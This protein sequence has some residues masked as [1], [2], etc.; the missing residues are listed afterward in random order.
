MTR[1][2]LTPVQAELLIGIV[3]F[4]R[5]HGFPPSYR[6]MSRILGLKPVAGQAIR[7]HLRGLVRKGW[8]NALSG[9]RVINLVCKTDYV[10]IAPPT[11]AQLASRQATK[12]REIAAWARRRS[13]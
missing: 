13:A 9:S 11:A 7:G 12:E 5:E 6:E 8:V 1:Q 4:M 3:R 10:V 2:P